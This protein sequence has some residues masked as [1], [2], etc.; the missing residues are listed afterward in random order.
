MS[1]HEHVGSTTR[2]FRCNDGKVML[3]GAS[4]LNTEILDDFLCGKVQHNISLRILRALA[5]RISPD[6]RPNRSVCGVPCLHEHL[7]VGHAVVVAAD[8]V[9]TGTALFQE[10]VGRRV[11]GTRLFSEI[12]NVMQT[13]LT[14]NTKSE[15]TE[16]PSPAD[17]IE[18]ECAFRSI[19]SWRAK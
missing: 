2:T 16:S 4:T 15:K 18:G 12:Y 3:H 8:L 6:P 14:T 11:R 5:T 17:E 7:V 1:A 10:N 13:P 19:K 9:P